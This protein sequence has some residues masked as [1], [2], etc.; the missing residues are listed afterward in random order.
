MLGRL[1]KLKVL[2]RKSPKAKYLNLQAAQ[3]AVGHARG[4]VASPS[5]APILILTAEDAMAVAI[6]MAVRTAAA[7]GG[8][9]RRQ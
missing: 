8:S 3:R 2:P 6:A 1:P 7:Q 5:D 4:R 9:R